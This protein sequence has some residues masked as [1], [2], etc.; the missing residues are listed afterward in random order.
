M[1][2]SKILRRMAL[3]HVVLVL[4]AAALVATERRAVRYGDNL[5]LALPLIAWGCAA[6]SGGGRELFVRFAVLMGVTHGTKAAL[7]DA[8]LNIRPNGRGDG[9]P[10]GHTAA[11][12]FGASALVHQCIASSPVG[13]ALVVIAAGFVGAS[14]IEAGKHT[15][16]QVL[17][18]ALLG[19]G[20]ERVLRAQTPARAR[21]RAFAQR[22][23]QLSGSAFAGL[24]WSA[25]AAAAA[26]AVAF[27][28]SPARGESDPAASLGRGWELSGYIGSQGA[29]PSDLRF[30]GGPRIETDWKG[31]SFDAPPYYGVRLTWWRDER[32]GFGVEINHAKVY[33]DD[34]TRSALGFDRLELTNGLNF[35]TANVFHRWPGRGRITPYVGA[36]IGLSV[37]HVDA[38]PLGQV[39][40]YGFQVTGP[41][42]QAV[43]GASYAI[44]PRWAVFGELKGTWSS[45]DV[46]LDSGQR[47]KTDLTT[48]AV[49]LGLSYRF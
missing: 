7:G 47:F 1:L 13:Q 19:W 12:A 44:N 17:A 22:T 41:V 35:V 38:S 20:M 16:W 49:N 2:L 45:N 26:L 28:S 4:L 15:I 29:L 30:E 24:R 14:R 37:P 33:A 43:V 36:G 18:G 6:T 48:G 3:V 5:Q 9:F 32:L 46:E 11:A 34:A 27:A 39:R 25:G 31:Q 10:S 42:V 23:G 8:P 40:T 21:L